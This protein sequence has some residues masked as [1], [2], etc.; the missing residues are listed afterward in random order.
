MILIHA[1]QVKKTVEIILCTVV[2][3]LAL[4]KTT[5]TF[6]IAVE[7]QW[8]KFYLVLL[9]VKNFVLKVNFIILFFL[10]DFGFYF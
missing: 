5:E 6:Q 2:Q 3:Q 8:E 7:S 10:L 1:F 4:K 9:I